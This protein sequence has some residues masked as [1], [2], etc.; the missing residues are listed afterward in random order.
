MG[1]PSEDEILSFID[2]EYTI[3]YLRKLPRFKPIKW[4]EKFPNANPLALDLLK[5]MLKFSPSER[6]SVYDAISHPY[7]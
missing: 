1:N 6:I 4:E 5:K 2:N 7:F 3:S